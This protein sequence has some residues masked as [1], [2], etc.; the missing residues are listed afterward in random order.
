MSKF[1][2]II[3]DE[4]IK[5][6]LKQEDVA[7]QIGFKQDTYSK[8]ERGEREPDIETLIKLADF[9]NLPLDY[10]LGRNQQTTNKHK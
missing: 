8:Y 2:E 3:K 6:N 4:R 9:Y 5:R 1:N 10:M 7:I